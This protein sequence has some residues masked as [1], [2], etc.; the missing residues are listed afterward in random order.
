MALACPKL[1]S[2]NGA[3]ARGATL[4]E[5]IATIALSGLILSSATTAVTASVTELRKQQR[6]HTALGLARSRLE[7]AI[8]LPCIA[9]ET[10]PAPFVCRVE[11]ETVLPPGQQ[12]SFWVIRLRSFVETQGGR[13]NVTELGEGIVFTTL[14]ARSVPCSG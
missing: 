14:V 7:A 13:Q 11:H 9:P 6:I 1:H 10:C 5:A 12:R 2:Q 8:G 3:R 4:L